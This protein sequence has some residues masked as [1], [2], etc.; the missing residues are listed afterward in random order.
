MDDVI[1]KVPEVVVEYAR[2]LGVDLESKFIE[3][4]ESVITLNP[5]DEIQLHLSLAEHFLNEGKSLVDRDAVQ[6]SEKLYK[7]AEECVKAL[8]IS[9]NYDDILKRVKERGKWTVTELEKAVQRISDKIGE[10]FYDAWGQA[11]YMHIWGFHEAKLDSEAIKRRIKY[12]DRMV[13]E[14]RK[15]TK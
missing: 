7:A 4:I 8:A 3:Y 14:A 5:K 12:I 2:K 11:N 6:A 1:I 13:R 15:Y 9:F 10:W